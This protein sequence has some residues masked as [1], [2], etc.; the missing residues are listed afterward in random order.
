MVYICFCQ[1]FSYSHGLRVNKFRIE[2]KKKRVN[3]FVT[4]RSSTIVSV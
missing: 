2:K 1:N 3:K 4:K